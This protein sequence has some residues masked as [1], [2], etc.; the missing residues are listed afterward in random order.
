MK[1]RAR[2]KITRNEEAYKLAKDGTLRFMSSPFPFIHTCPHHPIFAPPSPPRRARLYVTTTTTHNWNKH[3]SYVNMPAPNS[4]MPQWLINPNLHDKWSNL[5]W[6]AQWATE[7]QITQALNSRYVHHPN[8]YTM[9]ITNH[10]HV[11]PSPKYVPPPS[12]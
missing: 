5:L 1:I 2:A 12:P 10:W 11:A 8:M 4:N 6:D 7:A 3:I 9:P